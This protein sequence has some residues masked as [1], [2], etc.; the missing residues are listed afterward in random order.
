MSF[1]SLTIP[2]SQK[3]CAARPGGARRTAGIAVSYGTGSGISLC[4]YQHLAAIGSTRQ[5]LNHDQTRICFAP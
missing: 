3:G 1:N 4:D 2:D 5:M